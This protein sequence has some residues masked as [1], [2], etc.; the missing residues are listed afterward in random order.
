V[1][2]PSIAEL[3]AKPAEEVLQA[4]VANPSGTSVSRLPIVD[5][6]I[7]PASAVEVFSR[8]Q[9]NDVALLA[10]STADEGTLFAARAAAP[11]PS[12]LH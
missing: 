10:G 6:Y 12:E 1:S 2:A 7:L 9:Q 3:R 8:G 5:G 11:N 4:A